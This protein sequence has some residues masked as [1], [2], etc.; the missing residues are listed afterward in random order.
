MESIEWGSRASITGAIWQLKGKPD[1]LPRQQYRSR[2]AQG[3]IDDYFN[4]QRERAELNRITVE[5]ESGHFVDSR[6]IRGPLS[7]ATLVK[8]PWDDMHVAYFSSYAMW[9][10]LTIPFLENDPFG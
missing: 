3:T 2:T 5:T 7:E 10:Y 4:G 1:V 8:T 9:N 6:D